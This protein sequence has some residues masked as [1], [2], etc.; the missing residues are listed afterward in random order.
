[1]ERAAFHKI[2]NDDSSALGFSP[3]RLIKLFVR[4]MTHALKSF[5]LS[6]MKLSMIV[7]SK[8]LRSGAEQA[9][10]LKM[11]LIASDIGVNY[12]RTNAPPDILQVQSLTEKLHSITTVDTILVAIGR[13]D[14]YNDSTMVRL[15]EVDETVYKL[16]RP[17]AEEM[18]EGI[19][20]GLK[21]EIK[22][23][24]WMDDGFKKA[25]LAKVARISWSLLDDDLFYNDTALDEMYAE[26]LTLT[27]LSF[28]D[29]LDRVT[30]MEKTSDFNDLITV[31]DE[32]Q[33]KELYK[34]FAIL[35][36]VVNAFYMPAVNNISREYDGNGVKREWWK[37]KWIEQYDEKANCYVEQYNNV[38]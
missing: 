2:F 22:E 18:V 26:H 35:D 12:S 13:K 33:L 7:T 31:I 37:K 4:E 23:N 10:A 1:M 25:V 19:I 27:N 21:D 34:K 8:E 16:L 15:S 38:K 5:V 3:I 20:D 28:L 30:L 17:L 32:E 6:I 24:E 29:M 9:T 36:Y 14:Y 11:K